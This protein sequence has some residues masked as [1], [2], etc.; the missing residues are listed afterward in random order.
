MWHSSHEDVI[1]Q[2]GLANPNNPVRERNDR[3]PAASLINT[4]ASNFGC[5]NKCPCFQIANRSLD[6]FTMIGDESTLF[7][8]FPQCQ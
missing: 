1:V 2:V 5:H 4:L 6:C 8:D 7:I 3:R